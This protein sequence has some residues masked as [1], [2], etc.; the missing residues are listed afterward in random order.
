[1]T[2]GFIG[3]GKVGCS[4][5][6]Y[7]SACGNALS[8][9]YSKSSSSAREAAAFTGARCYDKKAQL[10][11]ESDVIF[12]TVPDDAIT[13]VWNEI[14]ELLPA[15]RI[16][17]HCSGVLSSDI[18]SDRQRYHVL[19]ASIHPLLAVSDK[20]RSY[21]EFSQALFTVEGD[22][23]GLAPLLTLFEKGKN[24]MV[25]IRPSDKPRY[26]A[27]AVM[28]SNLMLSLAQAAAKELMRCGFSE[29]EARGALIPF[30]LSNLG[31][32][33]ERPIP[34][35]LT[36]PLERG[37]AGTIEK[38]LSTLTGNHIDIYRALSQELLE[39]AMQKNPGRDY[40]KIRKLL[41]VP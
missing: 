11:A 38:H 32:A 30:A 15:G 8:G 33:N 25:R 21:R 17:C 34:E 35:C 3:A 23:N 6:K 39:V 16:I 2:I 20:L 9:Y 1:M 22:E 28:G 7:L 18:F 41:R 5:G 31:H 10:I 19:A 27:A 37:D 14:K 29:E 13:T 4:L 40:E 26:H 24:R 12:L 36:G